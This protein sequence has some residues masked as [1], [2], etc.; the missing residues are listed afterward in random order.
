MNLWFRLLNAYERIKIL[1]HL[2]WN[3]FRNKWARRSFL[4]IYHFFFFFRVIIKSG[5]FSLTGGFPPFFITHIPT[6]SVCYSFG[7]SDPQRN[8]TN[9]VNRDV[10]GKRGFILLNQAESEFIMLQLGAAGRTRPKRAAGREIELNLH[11]RSAA[12]S[13]MAAISLDVL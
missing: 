6:L 8:R 7:S 12:Y 1:N 9:T 13:F 2:I 11:L 10:R 4:A 3:A 5:L